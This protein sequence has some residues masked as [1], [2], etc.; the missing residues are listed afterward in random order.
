MWY[1][2]ATAVQKHF[3]W[4]VENILLYDTIIPIKKLMKYVPG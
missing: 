3:E 1:I 2:I 4:N